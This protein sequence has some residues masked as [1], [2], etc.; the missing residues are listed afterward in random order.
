MIASEVVEQ[1]LARDVEEA[2]TLI[3][4]AFARYNLLP[5]ESSQHS[6]DNP[7]AP[8]STIAAT[9]VD[10]APEDLEVQQ[11]PTPQQSSA[12]LQ[13]PQDSTPQ[14]PSIEQ[15]DP[16]ATHQE[17]SREQASPIHRQPSQQSQVSKPSAAQPSEETDSQPTEL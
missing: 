10:P 5:T 2:Y 3:I 17:Q 7:A 6:D 12:P 13:E 4:P 16:T 14:Q 11:S 1:G 8:A 15:Q 9:S